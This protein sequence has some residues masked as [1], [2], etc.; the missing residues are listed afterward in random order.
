MVPEPL[1][2]GVRLISRWWQSRRAVIWTSAV[3]A[4]VI[5]MGA[6]FVLKSYEF[7]PWRDHYAFGYQWGRIA[8]WLAET[9]MYTVDGTSAAIIAEPVYVFVIAA[10]FYLFGSFTTSAALGLIMFQSLLCSL[11]AWLIFI[12]AERIYGPL[13]ARI[14]SLLFAFYPASIFFAVG[15]IGPSILTIVLL[16]LIFLLTFT[17]ADSARLRTAIIAGFL[18]GSLM[19]LTGFQAF[20]VALIVPLWL[21]WVSKN[22]RL[23]MLMVSLIFLGSTIVVLIPWVIR[24]SLV[25]GQPTIGQTGL[26]GHLWRGNNPDATGYTLIRFPGG[27]P[28]PEDHVYLQ[29]A[30][31][32]IADH[33]KDFVLLTLKRIIIFW[34]IIP[35]NGSTVELLTALV[36]MIATALGIIGAL[37]PGERSERVWLLL[38]F[39]TIFPILFYVTVISHYRYRFFVE[40]FMLILAS[41]GIHRLWEILSRPAVVAHPAT[42]LST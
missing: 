26:E 15:R 11:A 35:R 3:L 6:C 34:S 2:G 18:T 29:M 8:K 25:T 22:Q 14:A 39:V 7:N 42:T 17:L 27:G 38:L 1:V 10:F 31:S 28:G 20:S 19:L 16:C 12:L 24:N 13:E 4:F 5:R 21:L 30:M 41:R 23:H 36:F 33:P 9:H 32:W 40:P 37:W